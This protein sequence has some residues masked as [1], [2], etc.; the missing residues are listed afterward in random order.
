ME[1]GMKKQVLSPAIE[2]GKEADLGSQMMGSA[3]MVD[4]VSAV[5]AKQNAV[6]DLL[7]LVSNGSD[8]FGHCAD[9]MKV[10]WLE[11]FGRALLD[12][13]RTRE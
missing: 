4:N 1:M 9:D 10:V 11:N 7:V 8:L 6:D 5:A 3:A 12:P 2:Y 13:L